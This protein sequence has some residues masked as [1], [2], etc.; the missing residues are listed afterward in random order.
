MFHKACNRGPGAS[1]R[2]VDVLQTSNTQQV[3]R[4]ICVEHSFEHSYPVALIK[5]ILWLEFGAIHF[6]GCNRT[7]H[8]LGSKKWV[9]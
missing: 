9:I 6:S 7:D 4:T 3:R 5:I 8:F 1:G 2:Q